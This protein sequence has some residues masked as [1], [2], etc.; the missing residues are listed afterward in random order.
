M[1]NEEL[2][3][4]INA[5]AKDNVSINSFPVVN[6]KDVLQELDRLEQKPD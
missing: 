1:T 2:R 6:T 5:V 3:Q 4:Y